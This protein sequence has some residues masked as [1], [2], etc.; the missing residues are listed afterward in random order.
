M[1]KPVSRSPRQPVAGHVLTQLREFFRAPRN[2]TWALLPATAGC[3]GGAVLAVYEPRG[4]GSELTGTILCVALG[5]GFWVSYSVLATVPTLLRG[6]RISAALR[7]DALT[8]VPLTLG[9][10]LSAVAA[11]GT[12]PDPDNVIAGAAVELATLLFVWALGMKV[13]FLP[14]EA[15]GLFRTQLV[16]SLQ[17]LY[18]QILRP[19]PLNLLFIFPG[20]IPKGPVS[21]FPAG[22][23]GSKFIVR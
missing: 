6:S 10:L 9:L 21:H 8:F 16:N 17:T 22:L 20:C 12:R 2:W 15:A 11:H 7:K 23:K 18:I 1:T 14:A 13:F 3:A 5:L 4:T 19:Q